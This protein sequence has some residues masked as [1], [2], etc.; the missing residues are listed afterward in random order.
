MANT[1]VTALGTKPGVIKKRE[2]GRATTNISANYLQVVTKD[3]LE[4]QVGLSICM[5]GFACLCRIHWAHPKDSFFFNSPCSFLGHFLVHHQ[6]FG[7][8]EQDLHTICDR[9]THWDGC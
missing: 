1:S 2:P 4:D 9:S 3:T 6:H 5:A 8:I 7:G